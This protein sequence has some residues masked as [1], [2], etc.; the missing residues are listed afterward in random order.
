ME[1]GVYRG[2]SAR[3]IATT[4]P[5]K[6]LHLFDTF[7]GIPEDDKLEGGHKKGDFSN[8]SLEQVKE[9]L[10]GFNVVY[11]VGF[12]PQTTEGLWELQFCFAHLDADTY[13][14]TTAAVEYVWPRLVEG[15][16]ILFDDWKWGKCRGVERAILEAGLT[17]ETDGFQAWSFSQR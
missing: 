6:T 8:T 1:F 2:G 15:G 17:V 3:V 12:F 10:N 13:Q 7:Q 9:F 14:S 11:H 4:A 5:Q 16:L